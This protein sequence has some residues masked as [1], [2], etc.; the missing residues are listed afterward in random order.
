MNESNNLFLASS[1]VIF[2]VTD[3]SFGTM[4]ALKLIQMV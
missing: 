4:D 1:D 3:S 2:N